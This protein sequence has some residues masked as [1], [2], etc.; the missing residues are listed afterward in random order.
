MNPLIRMYGGVHDD[1][2]SRQKFVEELAKQETPP[3][4]V[5]VE[6]DKSVFD[7]FVTWRPW[8]EQELGSRCNFLSP[9]DCRELSLA[10]AW[11][12]DAHTERFPTVDRLWLEIDFQE[13]DLKR[14]SGADADEFPKSFAH[15]L[16]ERLNTP[17]SRT[18]R[19]FMS[20]TDPPPAPRSKKELIDRVSGKLWSE[21]L[22]PTPADFGRDKR[23]AAAISERSSS[24]CGGWV[25][26]VV[27]WAHVDP[28][29]NS[30]RLCGLLS[31]NGFRVIPVC[32][33]P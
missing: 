32:L 9:G 15:S 26:I 33:A 19:E 4:F 18:M 2:G 24:P 8:I 20:N 6:W 5:A 28:A 23:W 13:A 27:G 12:G 29:G 14:R 16:L 17:C 7:R 22:P 30:R 11:E 10:L 1:P 3:H 31:S 21:P 25:A